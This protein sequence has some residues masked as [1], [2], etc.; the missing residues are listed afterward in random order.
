MIKRRRKL[1]VKRRWKKRSIFIFG[2]REKKNRNEYEPTFSQI[3]SFFFCFKF[4]F[5]NSL[6]LFF[7]WFCLRQKNFSLIFSFTQSTDPN[8]HHVIFQAR[9]LQKGC[10]TFLKIFPTAFLVFPSAKQTENLRT[11]FFKRAPLALGLF[12]LELDFPFLP[13]KL[14]FLFHFQTF[15]FKPR[16]RHRNINRSTCQRFGTR[17]RGD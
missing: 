1:R 3:Q 9:F 10:E 15:P 12:G 16:H 5:N 2:W 14:F 4:L 13:S 6:A 8:F 11:T 7:F 17:V